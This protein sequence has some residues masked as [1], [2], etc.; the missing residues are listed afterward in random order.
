MDRLILP[1]V[2]TRRLNVT[3][4]MSMAVRMWVPKVGAVEIDDEL[5]ARLHHCSGISV[6]GLGVDATVNHEPCAPSR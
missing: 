1:T 3:V 5:G 6:A 4:T 2:T